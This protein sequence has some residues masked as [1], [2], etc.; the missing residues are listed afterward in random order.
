ML[1]DGSPSHAGYCAF[2][3]SVRS[4]NTRNM[5]LI[6]ERRSTLEWCSETTQVSIFPEGFRRDPC[7]GNRNS[8]SGQ[9]LCLHFQGALDPAKGK[10]PSVTARG[11]TIHV[12]R[13][14]GRSSSHGASSASCG[15]APPTPTPTQAA[16]QTGQVSAGHKESSLR[17]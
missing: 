15:A 11:V 13:P 3:H 1:P 16:A 12:W 7:A 5:G 10:T 8:H 17:T 2:L 6:P 14:K 4:L 9:T